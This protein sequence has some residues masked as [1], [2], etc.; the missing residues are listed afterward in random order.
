[1][2]RPFQGFEMNGMS[3]PPVLRPSLLNRS[4]D[5]FEDIVHYLQGYPIEIKSSQHRLDLQREAK[6]YN[7]RRLQEVLKPVSIDYNPF[8][9]M[10]EIQ[11]RP[12]D[13]RLPLEQS[14]SAV[15]TSHFGEN[16]YIVT[17]KRRYLD[18]D[19][20]ALLLY[21]DCPSKLELVCIRE[22]N[23]IHGSIK[24]QSEDI[25][26]SLLAIK[27]YLSQASGIPTTIT[28]EFFA[29]HIDSKTHL[30]LNGETLSTVEESLHKSKRRQLNQQSS[31][32]QLDRQSWSATKI[33]LRITTSSNAIVMED[34][35]IDEL[36]SEHRACLFHIL[37][38][39]AWSNEGDYNKSK[40]W[41]CAP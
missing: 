4:E 15:P 27:Q 39:Q 41:C 12:E 2:E 31:I 29:F 30:I 38:I 9:Q 16:T 20:R 36:A 8:I 24:F 33:L 28:P 11:M 10:E 1:M 18:D 14:L 17:Y 13:I 34:N 26:A 37:K 7:F 23:D 40:A 21:I 32:V 5:L 6:F 19:A 22:H 25:N 3:R 35:T